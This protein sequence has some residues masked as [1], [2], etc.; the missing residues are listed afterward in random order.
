MTATVLAVASI[1]GF[2]EWV[3]LRVRRFEDV[4]FVV[5]IRHTH[6]ENNSDQEQNAVV[7]AP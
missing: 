5:Q 2:V 6:R 7:N 4:S 1:G 3:L